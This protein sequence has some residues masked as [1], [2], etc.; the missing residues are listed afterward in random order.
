MWRCGAQRWC[1]QLR[2]RGSLVRRPV[3]ACALRWRRQPALSGC[4]AGCRRC[5][6]CDGGSGGRQSLWRQQRLNQS[7]Q[8][9]TVTAA[10]MRPRMMD[11]QQRQ[12][13]WGIHQA[14]A[15]HPRQVQAGG[16]SCDPCTS[17]PTPHSGPALFQCQRTVPVDELNCI[18]S[19]RHVVNENE[20]WMWVIAT[21][22]SSRIHKAAAFVALSAQ[23][24]SSPPPAP[25]PRCRTSARRGQHQLQSVHTRGCWGCGRSCYHCC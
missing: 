20:Q 24:P 11:P 4:R 9:A 16:S 5:H 22:R 14:P 23:A 8:T 1:W 13:Q 10:A 7:V 25:L 15:S 18:P 6:C 2:R 21:T 19:S 3:T 17:A 12:R